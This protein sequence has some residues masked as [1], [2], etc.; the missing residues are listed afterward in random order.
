MLTKKYPVVSAI[1]FSAKWIF[2]LWFSHRPPASMGVKNSQYSEGVIFRLRQN[3]IMDQADY[4][5]KKEIRPVSLNAGSCLSPSAVSKDI[6]SFYQSTVA[7]DF[8]TEEVSIFKELTGT[9]INSDWMSLRVGDED[10]FGC[11]NFQPLCNR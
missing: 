9:A 10:V 11:C 8:F 3:G 7:L 1:Y 5:Q 6:G 2:G 4:S